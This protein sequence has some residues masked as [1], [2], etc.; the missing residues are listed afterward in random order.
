MPV[1]LSVYPPP[2][3]MLRD[4]A[5]EF[6]HRA[7]GESFASLPLTEHVCNAAGHVRAGIV[8]TAVDAI[9]GG[10]AATA[11]AP[12]WIA[13]ADLTLH[14]VAPPA[15]TRLEVLG[16]V[17]RAGRTTVVIEAEVRG[18][19]GAALAGM[20]TMTFSVLERRAGNP[21]L[22][23]PDEEGSENARQMMANDGS[24]FGQC[25]YDAFGI[26]ETRAGEVQLTPAPYIENSLGA[27][28]GG[29]LASLADAA[30]VS[31][32]GPG[33]ETVDLHLFYISLAKVGPI[34]ARAD[35]LARGTGWGSVAVAID[36]IGAG[37][38]TC[39]A[40]AVG[41]QS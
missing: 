38:H 25:A 26:A 18:N 3:H 36:D 37:R 28:Q 24:G 16:R 33:F 30:A 22:T 34:R 15:G 23:P 32:L 14:I 31:A 40:T 19:R 35:V 21:V 2:E 5:L 20:A 13:T 27:V 17:A 11:A 8:A 1:D 7:S 41:T 4:L 10:L 12:G 29:V 39:A 6:E 9:G